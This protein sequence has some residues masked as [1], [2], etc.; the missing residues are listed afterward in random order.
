MNKEKYFA[1]ILAGG[2]G[3]RF[4][5]VS[6]SR[7]PKQMLALVGGKP[8]LAQAIDRLRGLIPP[9]QIFIITNKDLVP[10]T[11]RMARGVPADQVIGEPMGRDTA[12]AVAVG[13]AL[14]KAR[15]PEAAFCILT[16]DQVIGDVPVF[17][18]TIKQSLDLALK[19]N[20][21]L[22]IGIKPTSP[23]TGFGYIDTHGVFLRKGGVTFFR[24]RRFVEKPDINTARKYVK[25]G[26]YYWNGG[27]FAWSVRSLEQALR[28]HRPVLAKL[29]N[30][31]AK[32][33]SCRS[34]TKALSREYPKLEKISIDYA[35]MEKAKNVVMARCSFAWDD[36]GSWTSLENHLPADA[37]GNIVMGSSE[38][39]Q[40]EKNVIFSPNHLTALLGVNN[41]VVI[42]AAGVTMVCTRDRAQDVK[43]LVEKL[44]A[45]GTYG[46]VL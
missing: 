8:M 46:K 44:K 20:I 7:T 45:A 12:A 35:L 13:G 16:A 28:R 25:A 42:Q 39:V 21:L 24:A 4:W 19:E 10:A 43:K 23:H 22:T 9:S 3:E 31:L 1:V 27:M 37:E 14:V 18:N 32:L 34:V 2:K 17:R 36:V 33:P 38:F 6:T 15:N 29:L 30:R 40:S 5:P 11:R 26:N 41:L